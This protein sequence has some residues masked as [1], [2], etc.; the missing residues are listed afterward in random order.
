MYSCCSATAAAAR[1]AAASACACTT[2]AIG[3]HVMSVWVGV[4]SAWLAVCR[5]CMVMCITL[6]DKIE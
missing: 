3:L 6:T 1:A 4:P 2:Y 5:R